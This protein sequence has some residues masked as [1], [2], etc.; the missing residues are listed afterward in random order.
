MRQTISS[1]ESF[2]LHEKLQ[3]TKISVYQYY[4]VG[5]YVGAVEAVAD[6][7]PPT[8]RAGAEEAVD[9]RAI[10]HTQ[11]VHAARRDRHRVVRP[12]RV[13]RRVRL[14]IRNDQQKRLI[15]RHTSTIF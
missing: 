11:V 1:S 8:V 13:R 7:M 10:G 14:G 15:T 5:A 4:S 12:R 6:E 3:V 2:S 9:W